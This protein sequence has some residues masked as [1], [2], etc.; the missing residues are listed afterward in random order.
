MRGR[1]VGWGVRFL[2]LVGVHFWKKIKRKKSGE[3]QTRE[4]VFFF[5]RKDKNYWLAEQ[6]HEILLL[7]PQPEFALSP[8]VYFK[9]FHGE[10]TGFLQ[11]YVS[12]QE[13]SFSSLF[14]SSLLFSSLLFSSLLFSSLLFSSLL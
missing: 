13:G 2:L 10:A 1:G 4:K 6:I 11:T 14:F 12:A 9:R 7:T 8:E 5:F 3:N